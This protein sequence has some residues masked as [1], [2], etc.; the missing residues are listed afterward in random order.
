MS[1]TDPKPAPE[2]GQSLKVESATVGD[3][4]R[5]R[6]TSESGAAVKILSQE[7]ATSLGEQML[8]AVADR[9]RP[10][11]LIDLRHVEVLASPV[12]GQLV[13]LRKAIT[14]RDGTLKVCNV[15][16]GLREVFEITRMDR[17]F[18]LYNNEPQALEA[19]AA[20]LIETPPGQSG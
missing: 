13:G 20:N 16:P 4:L 18:D 19:F 2:K 12:L 11:V 15:A 8:A 14:A 5:L 9:D 1:D 17:V 6:V 7:Q 3:I 10:R